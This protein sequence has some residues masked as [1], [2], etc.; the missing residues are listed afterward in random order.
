MNTRAP[1]PRNTPAN[2]TT[3]VLYEKR[4]VITEIPERSWWGRLCPDAIAP[5]HWAFRMTWP[6]YSPLAALEDCQWASRCLLGDAIAGGLLIARLNLGRSRMTVSADR[7]LPVGVTTWRAF[8]SAAALFAERAASSV[9]TGRR[10]SARSAAAVLL[11]A[12]WARW[13]PS[14]LPFALAVARPALVRCEI[15]AHSF[16]ARAA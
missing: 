12:D 8:N 6:V 4:S 3:N 7:G 11:A 13:S 16:S 10:A 14:C 9:N 5:A 2:F 1:W 15:R